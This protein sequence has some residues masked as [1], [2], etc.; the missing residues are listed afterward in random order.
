MQRPCALQ[1]KLLVSPLNLHVP[2][3][4]PIEPPLRSLDFG[5][6]FRKALKSHYS[7]PA[8]PRGSQKCVDFTVGPLN[9]WQCCSPRTQ[10]MGFWDPNTL[11]PHYLCPWT[12]WKYCSPRFLVRVLTVLV[13]RQKVLLC[14]CRLFWHAEWCPGCFL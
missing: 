7:A 8:V 3:I 5:Q 14:L 10:T 2:Y 13:S 12:L 1:S 11:K 9:D 6:E 4:M